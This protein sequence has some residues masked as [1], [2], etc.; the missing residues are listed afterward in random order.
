MI[1]IKNWIS[2]KN[3]LPFGHNWINYLCIVDEDNLHR[4]QICWF[5]NKV[6]QWFLQK[7]NVGKKNVKVLFWQYIEDL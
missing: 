1:Q 3:C 2:A 4:L 5:N 7:D 6:Y